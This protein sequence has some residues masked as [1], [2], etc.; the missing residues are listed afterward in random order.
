MRTTPSRRTASDWAPI[1]LL[2]SAVVAVVAFMAFSGGD[3]QTAAPQLA[4][5]QPV[6]A[7]AQ[8]PAVEPAVVVEPTVAERSVDL[9]GCQLEVTKVKLG[10]EGESVECVQK[11]LIV[12]GYY[13]GEATGVFDEATDAAARQFQTERELYVDGIVGGQTAESLGIW[14]GDDAFIVRTP[15]PPAGAQDMWGFTL[16]SVATSG[17]DTPPMPPNSGQGTGKRVVYDR[18]G[19]RTWAVDDEERVIRSFLVTGSQYNNEVPGVHKVYS[20][21]EMSTAWNGEANLP[22][23]IRWLDTE[24]GAIGFHGIPTHKSDGSAYQTDAELGQKLSGGCQRQNDLDAAFMWE[25]AT[26]GTPVYVT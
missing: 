24:R 17:S 21:S 7:A 19:Q 3:G 25:F 9:N 15:P 18:A 13:S 8:M 1:A 2:S 14:P 6:V 20:R 26:I 10:D 5:A 4:A 16:S 11:A 23:M 22:L 12:A